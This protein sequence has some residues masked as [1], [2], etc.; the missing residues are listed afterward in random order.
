[1]FGGGQSVESAAGETGELRERL[2]QCRFVHQRSNVT[3]AEIEPGP[4]RW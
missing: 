1:M 3:Q 4:L 2:P